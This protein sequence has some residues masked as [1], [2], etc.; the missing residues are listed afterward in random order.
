MILP[1]KLRPGAVI[2][3]ISPSSPQR[4]AARLD[5]GIAYLERLGY[6]VVV[7]EH[8]RDTYAGYLA[9]TDEDRLADLH[10]MFANPQIDAI[11]CSRGG[12]GTA[13]LLPHVDYDL[14]RRNPKIFVG[15]S[16]TTALQLA[17]FQRTGLVTYLGAMPSVDMAD[18]F[19]AESEEQFWNMLT[20]T[21]ESAIITQS[22]PIQVIK[23]GTAEGPLLGGNLSVFTTLIGTPYMPSLKGSILALED[24]GEEPYRIDRMLMHCELA[25]IMHTIS[26]LLF[27]HFTQSNQRT[28]NTPSRNIAD[29]LHE[30]SHAVNGPVIN[31]LMFGHEPKKLTL[32]IGMTVMV[33]GREIRIKHQ[34]SRS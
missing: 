10:S 21:S 18:E 12:Y 28:S 32:P 14:I 5:R 3:I 23:G 20:A 2:G 9:G 17:I 19:D 15:F 27:G 31:G 6:R 1:A 22:Q 34:E 8:A 33:E 26:G 25:G 29:I 4:D 7:G 11:M 24:I 30:R 13:R 16:D